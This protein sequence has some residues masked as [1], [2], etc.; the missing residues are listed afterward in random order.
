MRHR[1]RVG[2]VAAQHPVRT[3]K[4]QIARAA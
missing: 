3:T 4:P 2:R 1:L